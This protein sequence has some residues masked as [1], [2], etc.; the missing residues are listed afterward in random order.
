MVTMPRDATDHDLRQCDAALSRAF[1][2][3]GKRWNGMILGILAER[4][5]GFAELRRSLGQITDS[6]L[7]DRLSELTAAGLVSREV[8][9]S[10]PPGVSY[11]LTPAGQA[12]TPV[13]D[14]LSRWAADNLS[15]RCPG[16]G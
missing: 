1:E 3:L 12:L 16:T 14:D 2:F 10:R 6:V 5:A 4:P 13:L 8:T 7:S 11:G 15:Q 9:D